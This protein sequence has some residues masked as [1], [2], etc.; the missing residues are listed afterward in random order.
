MPEKAKER[1]NKVHRRVYISRPTNVFLDMLKATNPTNDS[2]DELLEMIILYGIAYMNKE[3]ELDLEE[4]LREMRLP[5]VD[6]LDA[7]TGL[8]KR[9]K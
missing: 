4:T 5:T 2:W 7:M 3:F 9:K 1:R 6:D 8:T